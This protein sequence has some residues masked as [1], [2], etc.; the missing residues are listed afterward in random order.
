MLRW[1]KAV[2]LAKGCCVGERLLRWRKAELRGYS[3]QAL[4]PGGGGRWV[5]PH[6]LQQFGY[7]LQFLDGFGAFELH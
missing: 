3:Q 7:T 5:C 2:A 1:R 6:L 4:S